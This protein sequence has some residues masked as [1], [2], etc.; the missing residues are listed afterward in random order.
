MKGGGSGVVYFTEQNNIQK[1]T[2]EI[3]SCNHMQSSIRYR[4]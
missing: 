4:D 2:I 3:M 1:D